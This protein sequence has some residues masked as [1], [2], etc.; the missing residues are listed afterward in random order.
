MSNLRQHKPTPNS[1]A[2]ASRQIRNAEAF[3]YA[4]P[5]WSVGT[6]KKR[7]VTQRATEESQRTAEFLL[8]FPLW[9]S[10]IPLRTLRYQIS[11]HSLALTWEHAPQKMYLGYSPDTSRPRISTL[12]TKENAQ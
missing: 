8:V 7:A 2:P 10:A 12:A 3:K 4:F 11:S 6:R 1:H 9:L 5:C